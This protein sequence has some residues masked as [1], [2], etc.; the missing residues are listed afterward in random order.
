MLTG[1]RLAT[2]AVFWLG[3]AL[4]MNPIGL[5]ITGIA[6]GAYLIYRYWSPIKRFFLGLWG[7]VRSAFA[8]GIGGVARLILKWSPLGLFYRAFAS[9]LKWFGIDLPKS[10]TDFGANLVGSLVNGVKAKLGAARDAIVGFGKDV[11]GWFTNTLGIKS[12][13]R[14]FMGF[15]DN[16]AQGTAIGIG[17]SAR[18]ASKA[19]AGMASDTAAA[20]AQRINTGRTGAGAAGAAAGGAGAVTIHFS[21]TIQVQGGAAGAVKGQITEALNIS[22]RELE[23]LIKRIAAQQTRRAY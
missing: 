23:Q 7:E 2:Q 9:V 4:F 8:A 19:A 12:P 13:S 6:M 3:R 22:L 10:F 21:P 15:G 17:R 1:L 20:A 16:I 14:V 5:A 18:L 11:K